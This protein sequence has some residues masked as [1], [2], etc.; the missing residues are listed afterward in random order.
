M[1]EQQTQYAV[2]GAGEVRARHRALMILRC[3]Q[4]ST[5]LAPEAAACTSCG[6]NE[7]ERVR[8]T[9]T[10]TVVSWT[11]VDCSSADLPLTLV[12]CTLAI[13]ELD[14]GPWIYT[15][16][17]G[18]LSMQPGRSLRVEFREAESGERFP[19]FVISQR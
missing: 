11:V 18:E 1:F 3:E 10:G 8:A 4:C 7:L 13:V 15:W 9:G 19:L 17:E 16:I 12:P 6:R 2:A 14:E 5:L